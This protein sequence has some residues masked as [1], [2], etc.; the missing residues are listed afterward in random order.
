MSDKAKTILQYFCMVFAVV[1]GVSGFYILTAWN[2]ILT[3]DIYI[4]AFEKSGV[5]RE[6]TN[7]VEAQFTYYLQ[8]QGK[9]LVAAIV[10]QEAEDEDRENRLIDRNLIVWGLNTIIDNRT[11]NVVSAISERVA[12]EENIQN[13][14]ESAL[15]RSLGWVRGDVQAPQVLVSIPSVEEMENISEQG[16]VR[17]SL[18]GIAFNAFG[19]SGL[20]ECPNNTEEREVLR[21][22]ATGDWLN[23]A[24]ITDRVTPAVKERIEST[25]PADALA[26]VEARI[27]ERFDLYKLDTLSQGVLDFV[28][29]LSRVKEQAVAHRDNIQAVRSLSIGLIVAAAVF[30]MG[31]F[32][33]APKKS[34]KIFV[35]IGLYTGILLSAIALIL[36][37]TIANRLT[38][39]IDLT[40][41]A[42][43][44]E[45]ISIAQATLLSKSLEMSAIYIGQHIHD[46]VIRTGLA[47]TVVFGV[48]LL[49][50]IFFERGGKEKMVN[51]YE[52][53]QA[54]IKSRTKKAGKQTK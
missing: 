6:V 25:I 37:M 49:I 17:D 2:R 5:Y 10:Q 51:W 35:Y 39:L 40:G 16:L 36:N 9:E 11:G 53:F 48:L 24:C 19:F 23:I 52:N 28:L 13:F 30:S 42:L 54:G 7:V 8:V 4:E 14:T 1:F 22:I 3:P 18:T 26:N 45:A 29:N 31:A 32:V 47:L 33:F 21:Q 15:T 27:Q 46:Y 38:G 50:T 43:N 44:S 34:A 20:P 12:L 41:F